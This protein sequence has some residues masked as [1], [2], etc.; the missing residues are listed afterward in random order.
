MLNAAIAAPA[1]SCDTVLWSSPTASVVR[2]VQ[3]R[4]LL[5]MHARRSLLRPLIRRLPLRDHLHNLYCVMML[6]HC[7]HACAPPA[8]VRRSASDCRCFHCCK[9]VL[10]PSTSRARS[11]V[12]QGRRHTSPHCSWCC[13]RLLLLRRCSRHASRHAGRPRRCI[14]NLGGV[15]GVVIW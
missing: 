10:A 13:C 6:L 4:R 8:C 5:Q 15:E 12:G 11:L 1:S 3:V 9:T 7:W 2:R 14:A